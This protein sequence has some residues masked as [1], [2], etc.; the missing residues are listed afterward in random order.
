[1]TLSTCWPQPAQVDLPHCRQVALLHIADSS[2]QF[3]GRLHVVPVTH[4]VQQ[5]LLLADSQGVLRV[6]PAFSA[7]L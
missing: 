3:G 4:L 1:M 2:Y 5:V 7:L 6:K